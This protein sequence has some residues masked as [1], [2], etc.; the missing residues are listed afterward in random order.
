MSAFNDFLVQSGAA[1]GPFLQLMGETIVRWPLGVEANAENVTAIVD[2]DEE[3]ALNKLSAMQMEHIRDRSQEGI[4]RVCRID[5]PVTQATDD[6]DQ[7]VID[8]EVWEATRVFGRD[9]GTKTVLLERWDG[10]Y[11]SRGGRFA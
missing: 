5:V 6:N 2:R 1:E 8:G 9:A 11:T 7:W 3:A 4:P 10:L